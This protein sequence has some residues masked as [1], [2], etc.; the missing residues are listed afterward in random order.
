M[1]KAQKIQEIETELVK[2]SQALIKVGDAL[3]GINADEE[4]HAE[5]MGFAFEYSEQAG[6]L[7]GRLLM[8]A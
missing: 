8:S 2:I 4:M 5:W 3:T 1:E 7:F 6:K